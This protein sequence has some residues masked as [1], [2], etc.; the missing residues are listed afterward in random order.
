MTLTFSPGSVFELSSAFNDIR[1]LTLPPSC[2]WHS[3][4]FDWDH[5][6]FLCRETTGFCR[7]HGDVIMVMLVVLARVECTY[8]RSIRATFTIFT[9]LSSAVH[10][11]SIVT[12]FS[13]CSR[14][15]LASNAVTAVRLGWLTVLSREH[16]D[17]KYLTVTS[18]QWRHHSSFHNVYPTERINARSIRMTLTFSTVFHIRCSRGINRDVGGFCIV[19]YCVGYSIFL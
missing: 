12:S 9:R 3:P 18:R 6:N 15:W 2:L 5:S 17:Y 11:V 4:A 14:Y 19:N 16:T 13:S 10:D 1:A 8:F 7:A